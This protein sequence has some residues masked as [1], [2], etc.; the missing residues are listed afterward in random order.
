MEA[1]DLSP[2]SNLVVPADTLQVAKELQTNLATMEAEMQVVFA[3]EA[4]EVMGDPRE[5]HGGNKVIVHTLGALVLYQGKNAVSSDEQLYHDT[6][7]ADAVMHSNF[8]RF[9]FI[10]YGTL[11]SLCLQLCEARVLA[12]KSNPLFVGERIRS[13]VF[14]PV[15][16]V[17]SLLAA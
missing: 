11:S 4:I 12:S 1:I 14:V 6:Y 15:H 16:S 8:S 13:G 5:L 2:R 10:R 9:T 17:E 3:A 7:F